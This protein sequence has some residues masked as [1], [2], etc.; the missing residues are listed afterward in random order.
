MSIGK[1]IA[2]LL[3]A[4]LLALAGCGEDETTTT[5]DTGVTGA[6]GATGA[7][8]SD[9]S[10]GDSAQAGG[11]F[12]A[13][14]GQLED[15]G[16]EIEAQDSA[17]LQQNAGLD[18]PIEAEAGLVVTGSGPGDAVVQQFSS[19]QDAEEVADANNV[20]PLQAE[21]VDGTIVVMATEDNDDLLKEVTSALGG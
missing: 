12:A 21:V 11:D 18:R 20:A 17:S 10:G 19:P 8:G 9:D 5:T 7:T 4:A 14:E 16:L 3:V 15:A 6:T 2:A 13:V 1:V